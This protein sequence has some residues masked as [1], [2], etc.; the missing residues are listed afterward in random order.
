MQNAEEIALVGVV[1]DLR[2]LALGEDVLDVERMPA[3]PAGEHAGVERVGRVE[4]NPGETGRAELSGRYR[5]CR[6]GN[7][8][9]ACACAPDARQ[10]RHRY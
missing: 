1:V 7:R 3:E 2:A 8:R 5:R 10:A 4:M 6:D 9:V